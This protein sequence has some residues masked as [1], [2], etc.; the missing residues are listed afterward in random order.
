MIPPPW[1]ADRLPIRPTKQE[2]QRI[3]T[4]AERSCE[5]TQLL[6]PPPGANLGFRAPPGLGLLPST[7][8]A[9]PDDAAKIQRGFLSQRLRKV[10]LLDE[11]LE[12]A[13]EASTMDA[14]EAV[15]LAL[16]TP[17]MT[18][19]TPL[20]QQ[21]ILQGQACTVA[22]ALAA[23]WTVSEE[24]Q[25]LPARGGSPKVLQ[26]DEMLPVT[27]LPAVLQAAP[28]PWPATPPTSA[29]TSSARSPCTS[30][31]APRRVLQSEAV[32]PG[33]STRSRRVLELSE[34]VQV[35]GIG[36]PECPSV[37]SV[38]HKL[39]LC[40]P[41]DFVHRSSCRA[42]AACEFCHLCEPAENRRRKKEKQRYTRT[43]R[44]LQSESA[45]AVAWAWG[46]PFQ[47]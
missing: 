18:P 1:P 47:Q 15:S 20:M 19:I 21:H 13:S 43:L 23:P 35:P 41:C 29:A 14:L 28:W 2:N 42:G 16:S 34:V 10:G 12:N 11:T 32:T 3:P 5:Q 40:K 7:P 27:P 33:P 46:A 38:G 30:G 9:R 17:P 36:S 39:G 45:V 31:Y 37:G 26:L 8:Q 6:Q 24:V 4:E 22:D 44:R 25:V